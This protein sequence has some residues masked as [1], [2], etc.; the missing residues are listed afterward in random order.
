VANGDKSD[1]TK[2]PNYSRQTILY[3]TVAMRYIT[4]EDLRLWLARGIAFGVRHADTDNTTRILL[5]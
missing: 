5:A 2:D 3:D 4:I 1:A